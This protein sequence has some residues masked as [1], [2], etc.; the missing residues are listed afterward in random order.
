MR[1]KLGESWNMQLYVR[2]VG[3]N[4]VANIMLLLYSRHDFSNTGLIFKIEPKLYMYSPV[5]T[6]PPHPPY[7]MTNA[8]CVPG[9]MDYTG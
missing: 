1:L 4:A 7:T 2:C 9:R 5:F 3:I 6:C 8:G